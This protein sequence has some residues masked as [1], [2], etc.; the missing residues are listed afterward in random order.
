MTDIVAKANII[1]EMS[2]ADLVFHVLITCGKKVIAEML[3]AAI[4]KICM[5]V[6]MMSDE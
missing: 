4:P 2:E 5:E 3:P 6:I 1:S